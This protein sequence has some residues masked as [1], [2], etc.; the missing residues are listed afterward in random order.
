MSESRSNFG[1]VLGGMI[2]GAV[3]GATAMFFASPRSGKANRRIAKAKFTEL[4]DYMD[5]ERDASAERVYD[6]LGDVNALT[7]SLYND[8]RRLWNSQVK[9]FEKSMDKIDKK[10]YLEMVDNVMEKL[11]VSK[12]YGDDELS[13]IKRYLNSQWKKLSSEMD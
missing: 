1:A 12:K 13:K 4:T 10:S 7:T 9:T 11:Q 3:A 6:I 2:M 8:A 5:A